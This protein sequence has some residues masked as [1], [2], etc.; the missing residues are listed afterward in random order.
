MALE[1]NQFG[2]PLGVKS[3]PSGSSL[4]AEFG[5]DDTDLEAVYSS[6]G[7]GALREIRAQNRRSGATFSELHT[8]PLGLRVN[9][10]E[11]DSQWEYDH[12]SRLYLAPNQARYVQ[13]ALESAIDLRSSNHPWVATFAPLTDTSGGHDE[14]WKALGSHQREWARRRHRPLFE[15]LKV[16]GVR[17][18]WGEAFRYQVEA[19]A[20]VSL[21]RELGFEMIVVCF[22]AKEKGHPDPEA[23]ENYRLR[24]TQQDLKSEAG[25]GL[26]VAV[27]A[28]CTGASVIASMLALGDR[29]PVAYPNRKDFGGGNESLRAEFVSLLHTSS[30]SDEQNEQ[31][32]VIADSP[33][34]VLQVTW[35]EALDYGVEVIGICCGGT[36][37]LVR[38]AR[39]TVDE[40]STKMK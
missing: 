35:Q 4:R 31:L 38:A 17:A 18:L 40:H 29:F 37:D 22:E 2:A 32:R 26:S 15:A 33:V 23:A 36:Q 8:F 25:S 28:N 14:E 6:Q 7:L 34:E 27:G 16:G 39:C 30:R 20:V 24:E 19:E 9:A 21:A 3:G 13:G 12:G 10:T 1:L 5:I 11:G